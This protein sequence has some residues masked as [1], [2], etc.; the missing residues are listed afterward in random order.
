MVGLAGPQAS[1]VEPRCVCPLVA[2]PQAKVHAVIYPAAGQSV[3]AHHSSTQRGDKVGQAVVHLRVGMVRTARK[4]NQCAL[5][6][7]GFCIDV[8]CLCPQLAQVVALLVPGSTHCCANLASRQVEF[9]AQVA[10]QR[11]RMGKVHKGRVQHGPG[12]LDFGQVF[13]HHLRVTAGHRAGERIA[14]FGKLLRLAGYAGKEDALYAAFKQC[15]HMTVRQFGRVTDTL[16]RYGRQPRR[17]QR[18]AGGRRNL[19][20]EAQRGEQCKPERIVRED[21]EHPWNAQPAAWS[22]LQRQRFVAE[23]PLVFPG[24]EVGR[25]NCCAAPRFAEPVAP[26]A[27]DVARTVRKARFGKQTVVAAVAAAKAARAHGQPAYERGRDGR[28]QASAI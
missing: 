9:A 10:H 15:Q 3:L 4:H 17:K 25:G 20:P 14:H 26:V 21:I 11:G 19:Y 2:R 13:A 8:L 16:R 24:N 6:A 12:V 1:A 22:G 23:E 28:A 18:P 7:Q 27:R 5:A